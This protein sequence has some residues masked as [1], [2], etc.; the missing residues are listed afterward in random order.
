MC[1]A[2]RGDVKVCRRAAVVVGGVDD[3]VCMARAQVMV[4]CTR[5]ICDEMLSIL[6][7]AGVLPPV[8]RASL[9]GLPL[10]LCRDQQQDAQEPVEVVVAAPAAAAAAPAEAPLA[11]A[12]TN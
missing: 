4:M 9:L 6:A 7:E 2:W 1:A 11:L 12:A 10:L 8:R 5:E 3:F